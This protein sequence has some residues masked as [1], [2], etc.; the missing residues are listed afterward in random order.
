[1]RCYSCFCRASWYQ[2]KGGAPSFSIN[3]SNTE[4]K[5]VSLCFA[6]VSWN[7]LTVLDLDH[8]VQEDVCAC[9]HLRVG[10]VD[11]LKA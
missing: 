7:F 1:M 9:P 11:D 6:K 4:S 3:R 5:K 2:F 10:K 8:Q